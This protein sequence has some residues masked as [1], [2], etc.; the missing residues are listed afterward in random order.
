MGGFVGATVEGATT[1]LGRGGSDYTAAI[2]GAALRSEEIQIWTDVTGVL[3][4]DPR[5]V[6]DAQTIERLSYSE[7]AELAYFGAKVLHPE[8]DSTRD[9]RSHSGADLQ[10]ARAG[11]ARHTRR[12]R[13]RNL[14][15]HYQSDRS[16]KRRDDGADYFRAHARRLRFSARAL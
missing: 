2:L 16:Q 11:R 1:T 8:N 13:N 5:V 3:T 9:R 7:A 12:T 6:P 15:T 4:A 14:A 10:L